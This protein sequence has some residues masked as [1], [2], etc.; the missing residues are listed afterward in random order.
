MERL[1]RAVRRVHKVRVSRTQVSC[2]A[3]Q[4]VVA[5]ENAGR[6][7]EDA[8]IGVEF[9][10]CR[11][12]AGSVAFTENLLEVAGQQFMNP[13]RHSASPYFLAGHAKS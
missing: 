8:V 11:T 7:I 10:D 3:V 2:E 13:V 9:L 4:C 1:R 12:T 5:D 6:H